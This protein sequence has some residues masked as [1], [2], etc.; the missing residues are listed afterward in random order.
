VHPCKG[1]CGT[2]TDKLYCPKCRGGGGEKSRRRTAVA[3][4]GGPLKGGAVHPPAPRP[5]K[6][7]REPR[8]EGLDSLT[9][10]LYAAPRTKKTSN[11]LQR[12][13]GRLKVVPSKAWMAWRDKV[14]ASGDVKPWMRLRDQPYNCAAIFY[15]DADRG[16]A[17]GYMQSLADVLEEAGVVSNDRLLVSWDGTRLRVDRKN[18]RV[19]ITLT[20]AC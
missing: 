5:R 19:E 9:L 17:T 8:T 7:K 20:R 16:D 4:P 14:L 3:R 11:Q 13:G 6:T 1:L 15:R 2:L 12:F 18:P 10:T